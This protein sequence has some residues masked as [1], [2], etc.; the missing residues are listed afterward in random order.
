MNDSSRWLTSSSWE[1]STI[2]HPLADLCNLITPYFTASREGTN[3]NRSFAPG[4]IP[5]LPELVEVVR[6]YA[7]V[8]GYD[9]AP[10]LSWG[11]AFSTWRNAGICQGIAARIALRQASSEK[12][13][14][15]AD[16]RDALAELA[17][18]LT[19]DAKSGTS[20]L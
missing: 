1:M 18:E 11:M 16:S 2:G 15:Y 5:G 9:P 10:E 3:Q 12:A 8:S 20:R 6:W 7:E 17:W 4:T 13:R 19:A 14:H